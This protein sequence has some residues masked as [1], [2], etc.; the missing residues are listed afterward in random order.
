MMP[1]VA[2]TWHDYPLSSLALI[3]CYPWTHG[4]A[5]LMGDA[6]H[7]TVPFYG[8]GMNC[9]FEDCSVMWELMQKHQEDWP[10]VF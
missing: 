9:G 5:A 1:H 10:L 2:D 6:A 4:K 3:R 7:A 8:Q